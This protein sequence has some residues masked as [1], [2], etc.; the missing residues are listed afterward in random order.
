MQEDATTIILGPPGTGKTT[1]LLNIVEEC[2]AEGI[3][4]NRIGFMSFTKKAAEEGRS[5]AS[6]RFSLDPEDLPHFRTVH[7]FA[8]KHLGMHRDQMLGW[9]HMRELGKYLGMDFKGKDVSE[10]EVY[11]MNTAD[12]MLFLDGLAK[13]TK[14]SLKAVWSSAFEDDINWW[15]LERF[16]RA[17]L[18]YK[19]AR[20]LK[21]FNDILQEFCG[22]DPRVFPEFD[23]LLID[24]AQDLS[25]LQWD[26]VDRLASRSAKVY[27]GGDDCQSVFLWSGADVDRFINLPGKQVTLEQSYRVP[28][29]VHSLADSLSDRIHT[30]RSRS[31]KPREELGSVNWF[32][33]IEE[34]DLSKDTW[35]LLARNGYML[36]ELEEWCMTQGFSFNSINHDPLKGNSLKAIKVW[37]TLRKGREE[38]SQNILDMLRLMGREYMS[39]DLVAK[40][41]ANKDN[42]Q[43]SLTELTSMGLSTAAPWFD[44]LTKI[45]ARETAFFRAAWRRG[46]P[47]LKEPR[48]KISTIHASKG[49]QADHVLLMTDMSKR[50]YDNMQGSTDEETRVWYVAAT[51][52]KQTLNLVMPRTN[53]NFEL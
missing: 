25:A 49:G 27:V 32:A 26:V 24:E 21:D 13:G 2:L 37:E 9:S 7:S 15:E 30:K 22:C 19:Q 41:K 40:L 34:I 43:Y 50:C 35:M 5:R 51:R 3:S 33:G 47:L 28:R 8:F 42:I 46:E 39:K 23:V 36:N 20:Q 44:C 14:R 31:W 11:G 4:P 6:K 17:L 12:R 16:S 53:L 1:K 18:E 38:S 52:C 29:T 45:S 48:I 10:D